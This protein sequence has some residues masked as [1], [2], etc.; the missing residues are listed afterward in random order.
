[1]YRI[2]HISDLHL[3][4]PDIDV[5]PTPLQKLA[6]GIGATLGFKV[7]ATP[8]DDDALDALRIALR[9]LKPHAILVTGDLTNYGDAQ[10]FEFFRKKLE[11]IKADCK[12]DLVLAVPGNHDTLTERAAAIDKMGS[13]A[14]VVRWLRAIDLVND[15]TA[16]LAK[17]F[18]D[19]G[20]ARGME[21]LTAYVTQIEPHYGIVD[22]AQPRV[23]P[24]GWGNIAVFLFNSNVDSTFMA[25][26]GRIGPKRYNRT[27]DAL[28]DESRSADFDGAIKIALLHHHPISA[29][30]A[31][32]PSYERFY[33]WMKD[34]PLFVQFLNKHG[35]QLILHG[36]QHV[37]FTAS[38][39][40]QRAETPLHIVAAGAA[41]NAKEGS[42]NVIDVRSPFELRVE[43]WDY[44]GTQFDLAP[45]TR[46][47]LPVRSVDHIRLTTPNGP[48]IAED[49][50]VRNLVRVGDDDD[51][52]YFEYELLEH[53]VV[54]T[55]AQ[56]YLASY[57]RKG[58]VRDVRGEDGPPFV[59]V[60][61]PGM[62]TKTMN[63]HGEQNGIAVP[64]VPQLGPDH[65]T[66][67]KFLVPCPKKL[68][69]D[70]PFDVT[71]HFEWQA[72]AEE[73][74][75]FD[76]FNFMGLRYPVGRFVY[77][78]E[79]PWQPA[80]VCVR[81]FALRKREAVHDLRKDLPPNTA[82]NSRRQITITNPKPLVY[83]IFFGE[84][85]RHRA[86][87]C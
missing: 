46:T 72:S 35:F 2:A 43:R 6:A 49:Y 19:K 42:F 9:Q 24:V 28:S 66:R 87:D 78:V 71:L 11:A 60:G 76:G 17:H 67:K 59:I 69:V 70:D 85:M 30:R 15:V 74:N 52:E 34:G 79:F 83:L 41:T 29:P 75:D 14:A 62:P 5:A 38:I 45:G 27:L 65:P 7:D 48:E 39:S 84:T 61:S 80:Q 22:S 53:R 56:R 36:H 54:I 51:D 77:D 64:T 44:D 50:A 68:K 33:N 81:E 26:A 32:D 37:P 55:A 4:D 63:V 82:G 86:W 23:I 8:Y 31:L 25:N 58:C 40:Y 18:D 10:S 21:F 12:A 13:K 3:V 47:R 73:P 20:V 57:R 16:R 1:V